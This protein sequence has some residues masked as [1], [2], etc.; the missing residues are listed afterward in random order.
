MTKQ[1]MKMTMSMTKMTMTM[2]M[3][4]LLKKMM[5]VMMMMMMMKT[6]TLTLMLPKTIVRKAIVV[7]IAIEGKEKGK[8]S[9][10]LFS[11]HEPHL[12]SFDTPNKF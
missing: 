11:L 10:P 4:K 5:M 12:Q 2:T 8:P 3:M 9:A 1:T 7:V 6:L